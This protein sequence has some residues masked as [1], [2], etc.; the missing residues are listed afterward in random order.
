MT[1]KLTSR[2][3]RV[4]LRHPQLL[5]SGYD[6]AKLST[7]HVAIHLAKLAQ[8]N[9]DLLGLSPLDAACRIVSAYADQR[10]E[11][12]SCYHTQYLYIIAKHFKPRI[13]VETGVHY[14]VS[15]AFILKGLEATGGKL[16]S[17]DL[18]N[19][20]Y[21][22]D[23]GGIHADILPSDRSPGFVVPEGLRRNWT[24]ILGD[25]RNELPK[26]L[27]AIGTIDTFH[28]DS[29]NTHELMTFEYETVLPYLKTDGLL[30]SDDVTWNNAFEDFCNKHLLEHRVCGGIGIAIKT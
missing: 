23:K 13:F 8:T 19:V 10:V 2:N 30:L 21:K 9:I 14:G 11:R 3:I 16:Y 29:M 22:T 15:S 17:I 1:P 12:M 7:K 5:L 25:A 6:E 28:H 27:E 4:M 20:T 24:L 18:P 26:L